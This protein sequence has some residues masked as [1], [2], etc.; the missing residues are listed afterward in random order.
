[1]KE[2]LLKLL[3]CTKAPENDITMYS[4]IETYE[5]MYQKTIKPLMH[6]T[7]DMK[8]YLTWTA[9]NGQMKKKKG[10]FITQEI[11]YN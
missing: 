10:K 4:P 9:K 3:N 11:G 8:K 1:M 7:D 6:S 2:L 5:Y